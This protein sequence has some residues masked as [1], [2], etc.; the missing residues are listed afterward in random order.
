MEAIWISAAFVLGMALRHLGLPPLIGFLLAG[1]ALNALGI[2]SREELGHIAHLGVLLLLFTVGLKL[3][4]KSVFRVEVWGSALVHLGITVLVML[5]AIRVFTGLDWA[6]S[7]LL[8]IAF[9][10]SS[11]VLAAK[12]LTE[13]RELKSFHGRVAIGILIIQ[14]LVAVAVLSTSSG[15]AP[16]PLALGV[17]AVPLLRPVLYRLMDITGRGELLILLGMVLALGVGGLGFE[18]VGLSAELGAVVMGAMLAEH[19]RSGDLY[20][21]LWGLKEFFLVAFFLQIGMSGMPDLQSIGVALALAL[22]LPLKAGLFFLILVRFRLRART[23]FLTGLSLA[24]YSEF[25][26]IVTSMAVRNGWLDES[27]LVLLAVTVAISFV[28]ASPLFR[29]AHDLFERYQE[30]LDRY[31]LAERHPDEEPLSVGEASVLIVGMGKV[32]TAAYDEMV[33]RG[34]KVAGLDSDQAKVEQHVEAERNV[35][36]GDAEDPA[37]WHYLDLSGIRAVM[38]AMPETEAAM[39]ASAHLRKRGY[40]GLIGA[41]SGHPDDSIRVAESGADLCFRYTEQAGVGFA[42]NVLEALDTQP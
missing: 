16:S 24:C 12:L 21:A 2:G 19:P 7:F 28:V 10:F 36:Y 41:I 13:K 32:A 8:A 14:D 29:K 30:T 26:L 40:N 31:E 9:G 11:T 34:Q 27:W 37:L 39:L 42:D 3:K 18:S 38:L 4:L 23:A 35:L 15:E 5:P 6:I 25:G 33:A 22:L 20:G 1:F 17:F